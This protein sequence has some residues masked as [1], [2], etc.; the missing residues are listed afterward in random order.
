MADAIAA[1]G[2]EGY[3]GDLP[4][5]SQQSLRFENVLNGGRFGF[6]EEVIGHSWCEIRA[7]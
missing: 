7:A 5:V 2:D 4:L 1:L 6:G 3:A